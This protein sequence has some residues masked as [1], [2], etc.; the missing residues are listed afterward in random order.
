MG[1]RQRRAK[2]QHL[3]ATANKL[4]EHL[5]SPADKLTRIGWGKRS[6]TAALQTAFKLGSLEKLDDA[7][8]GSKAPAG[9]TGADPLLVG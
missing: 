1:R 9:E 2:K 7:P 3:I 5:E 6:R 4:I 8:K